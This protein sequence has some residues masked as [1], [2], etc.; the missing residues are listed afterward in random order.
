MKKR[1]TSGGKS[2]DWRTHL[3]KSAFMVDICIQ[4]VNVRVPRSVASVCG[5][6]AKAIMARQRSSGSHD[7]AASPNGLVASSASRRIIPTD[8]TSDLGPDAVCGGP[9]PSWTMH[10]GDMYAGELQKVRKK[11]GWGWG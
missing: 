5:S 9:L 6:L 8:Q 1:E 11:W 10:S 7:L 3:K 4:S 2:S